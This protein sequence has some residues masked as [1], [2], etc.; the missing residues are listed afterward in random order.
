M[1]ATPR[2]AWA[3]T[4]LLAA[5][6]LL[7][8][9]LLAEAASWLVFRR[10]VAQ[11]A[12][13]DRDL[14][15][16]ID[17][18][19]MRH[20][21]PN[22]TGYQPLWDG[23]GKAAFRINAHG[24]RG[25]DI[26]LRKPPGVSRLLFLGDSITIGWRLREEDVFVEHIG[27][28][29]GARYEVINAGY[30]DAGL[31]EED[32]VLRAAGMR[33]RPDLVV[34]GWYLNDGRPPVGFPEEVVYRNPVIRWIQANPLLRRS[35][36]V[37]LFYGALRKSL[38]EQAVK[39]SEH[40][41][42]RFR[43]VKHY[44]D[45]K[46]EWRVK[47]ESLAELLRLAKYDFGDG[48]NAASRQ[49]MFKRIRAMRDYVRGQGGEFAVVIFPLHAQVYTEVREPFVDEPQ[50]DFAAFCRDANIP[51]LDLLPPLRGRQAEELFQDFCHYTPRGNAVVAEEILA[52]LRKRSLLPA[53]RASSAPEKP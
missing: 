45:Q 7:C 2:R 12:V 44:V 24:F 20:H 50:R 15:Y 11:L 14:Y 3:R 46:H 28:A 31:T 47:P 25:K 27:R 41:S 42:N 33:L 10:T 9:L 52:F 17:T 19:G 37:G 29:L 4:A 49:A 16:Y 23:K 34:L 5:C 8:G 13:E 48:W 43:W 40:K 26:D 30:A 38:V 36:F 18:A 35:Y 21:I 6:G 32:A 51:C 1:G 53:G 22:R 39:V